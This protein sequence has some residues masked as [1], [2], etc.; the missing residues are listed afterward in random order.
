MEIFLN[1]LHRFH[2]FDRRFMRP[3][4]GYLAY[5]PP[6]YIILVAAVHFI[7]VE[8]TVSMPLCYRIHVLCGGGVENHHCYC[9]GQTS[10]IADYGEPL[11]ELLNSAFKSGLGT[12]VL[13][14]NTNI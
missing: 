12:I 6:I 14:W 8:S 9:D 2:M 3:T 13:V 5:I 11:I 1:R 4:P 7:A 10:I